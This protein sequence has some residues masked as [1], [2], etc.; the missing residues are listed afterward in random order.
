MAV[1]K[2][3][4][5]GGDLQIIDGK[6]TAQCEYC[7]CIQ[8]IASTSDEKKIALFNRANSLRMKNEF[9][10]A[11]AT[12]ENI[13][14]EYP[15]EVE[16]HWG[17]LLC[18]YGVEYVDDPR[19]KE[20]VPTCNRTQF[21]YIFDDEDYKFVINNCDVISKDLYVKEANKINKIQRGILEISQKEDPFDIF[22]CYKETEINSNQRTIDSVIAQDIY[23]ELTKKGY[24]V[25][26]SRVTLESKLGTMYEPYIFAA[27]NSSKVMLVIGSK[28]EHFNAVWVKN[29][30]SRYLE[31][32]NKDSKKYMIPCYKNMD[33]YDIPDEMLGFQSQD[34]NKIGFMQDLTRGI[35]KLIGRDLIRTKVES[36]ETVIHSDVNI[37]GLLTRAQMLIEDGDFKKADDVLERVLDNDPKN[38]DAYFY[39]L[40]VELQ[41]KN[42]KSL[43]KAD[44]DLPNYLNFTKAL[45]FADNEQK[46]NLEKIYQ[47]ILYNRELKQKEELYQEAC[48]HRKYKRFSAAINLFSKLIGYKDSNEQ[49]NATKKDEL[50][51][52]YLNGISSMRNNNFSQAIS[53]FEKNIDYKDSKELIE[54][55]RRNIEYNKKR[56]IYDDAK[57]HISNIGTLSVITELEK[58][59]DLLKKI[60]DFLDSNSL[61]KECENKIIEYKEEEKR[62]AEEEEKHRKKVK[63][64]AIRFTKIFAVVLTI[65]TAVLT[66]IFT[67]FIPL[68]KY[69]QGMD[70]LKKGEFDQA[71]NILYDLNGFLDS[72]K[73]L[74]IIEAKECFESGDY[75]TAIDHIYNIGGTVNVTYDTKG[76]NAEKTEEIIKKK[77]KYISNSCEKDGYT[78]YGWKLESYTMSNRNYTVD[79]KL[80]AS[81]E[82]IYYNINLNVDGGDLLGN[83]PTKYYI[84]DE[85]SIPNCEKTGYSFLGWTSYDIDTP[86]KDLV[87]RKGEQGNKNYTAVYAANTYTIYYD[88]GYDNIKREQ[89]VVYDSS[90]TTLSPQRNGY[91]FLGWKID[92]GSSYLDNG[93]FKNTKNINVK[94]QWKLKEYSISY[95]LNGGTNNLSNIKTFTI[96]D[97]VKIFEP[98]RL[99]YTFIGWQVNNSNDLTK[100]YTIPEGTYSNVSL[101]A[102]WEANE[103]QITFDSDGG[104][105]VDSVYVKYD[106]T[107]S[108]PLSEKTGYT[109]DGW[110]LENDEFT[111]NKWNLTKNIIL[112]AKWSANDNTA[113]VVNHNIEELNGEYTI[114]SSQKLSATSDSEVTPEVL[115][116]DGFTSPSTK[117]ITIN[118]DGSS[119]LDYYYTRNTY[120]LSY[121]SNGGN[122][123]RSR[124]LK[125]EEKIDDIIP[126]RENYTFGGWYTDVYLVNEFDN[127]MPSG[128]LTIYAYWNEE[129]KTSCFKFDENEDQIKI[130][131]SSNLP[132]NVVVPSYI[133]DDP[134]TIIGNEAFN[135][136]SNITSLYIPDNVT[137]M[138]AD[139]L[140]GCYSLN[141]LNL[142]FLGS[143][144]DDIGYN[145]SLGYLFGTNIDYCYK[146]TQILNSYTSG[147]VSK[148][149]WIPSQLEKITIRSGLIGKGTLSNV[150]SLKNINIMEDV[151]LI[152]DS[153][154]GGCYNLAELN[155]P[156]IGRQLNGVN[157]K[158]EGTL[159]Y[160][161][162]SISYTNSY[163]T[164]NPCVNSTYPT[165][166]YLPKSLI[167]VS[168]NDGV[169]N[170]YA[171]YNCGYLTDIVLNDKIISIGNHAFYSVTNLKNLIYSDEITEIEDYAFYGCTNLLLDNLPLNLSY[172]G[173]YAFSECG[174]LINISIFENILEIGEYVFSNCQNLE[175]LEIK[176]KPNL[177]GNSILYNSS[178]IKCI[179]VEDAHG[180]S[181]TTQYFKNSVPISLEKVCL[182]N[183]NNVPN[184]YFSNCENIKNIFINDSCE[185]IGEYAFSDCSSLLS[186]NIPSDVI[187]IGGGAFSGCSINKMTLPLKVKKIGDGAFSGA[188]IIDLYYKGNLNSWCDIE[189]TDDYSNPMKNSSYF[190]CYDDNENFYLP[191]NLVLNK[192][193]IGDYQ[194]YGGHQFES[195]ELKDVKHVGYGAFA[196][197]NSCT[198]IVLPDTIEYMGRGLFHGCSSLERITI[199]YLL[200]KFIEFFGNPTTDGLFLNKDYIPASL[201]SISILRGDISND[202]FY[203][204][205]NLTEIIL[206]DGVELIGSGAFSECLNLINVYFSSGL[207]K[208]EYGAFDRCSNLGNVYYNGTIEDWCNIDF[209]NEFSNPMKFAKNFYLYNSDNTYELIENI[210]MK[211]VSK[212]GAY[213][214]YGFEQLKSFEIDEVKEIGQYAFADCIKLVSLEIP[215]SV[216]K[217]NTGIFSGCVCLNYLKIPF[218]GSTLDSQYEFGDLFGQTYMEGLTAVK[219]RYTSTSYITYYLPNSLQKVEIASGVIKVGAFEN[220]EMI[221]EIVLGKN[222]SKIDEYAFSGCIN[223]NK[224]EL[225]CRN[226]TVC[227]KAF[228]N[229]NA[230]KT[231]YYHGNVMDWNT[232]DFAEIT[233]HPCKNGV[234]MYMLNENK[235]FY[236]VEDI[237][238][239][240][241]V[242]A[243]GEY[244]FVGFKNVKNVIISNSVNSIGFS[245][246]NGCSNLSSIKLPF[247]GTSINAKNYSVDTSFGRIFGTLSYVNSISARQS[248]SSD[249]YN[250]SIY[251]IPSTLI[252][253]EITN[254]IF[255][256]SFEFS[257][258]GTINIPNIQEIILGENIVSIPSYTFMGCKNM[259]KLSILGNVTSI[260]SAAFVACG[261]SDIELPSTL[262]TVGDSAFYNMPNLRNVYFKGTIDQ[263]QN[264]NF[265]SSNPIKNDVKLYILNDEEWEL[266]S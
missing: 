103:Y 116:L 96:E 7:G 174:S 60:P 214:F 256:Y 209:G 74:I 251:Q 265:S 85:I 153:A 218:L 163:E 17:V 183:C 123:I 94:A 223:I 245:S 97:S 156:F 65:V 28:Q 159:G 36:K 99:G 210:K 199:P 101:K 33:A 143:S 219:Q 207:T 90:F 130:I 31:L 222:I 46:V 230:L 68:S 79:V 51:Y 149:Y 212:I 157:G 67:F 178:S 61:I 233:G 53:I 42:I 23:D 124:K 187:E 10:K 11:M 158:L 62:K 141:S 109:F 19:T 55:C 242:T 194:F 20:K 73:Q 41:K 169:V 225:S 138:K 172:L 182:N 70:Y 25:F 134:V 50:E 181:F 128:N 126:E 216:E 150:I 250:Y 155:L 204:C 236:L 177:I 191:V 45:K 263:W 95:L 24:K 215:D 162:G 63:A 202:Y 81:Y 184:R 235:N 117:K 40:L 104:S 154:F 121:V 200:S 122:T 110:Y 71:Y 148:T 77:S 168:I 39:K 13:I 167:K 185:F 203:N 30:W 188:K 175:K 241:T 221:N 131:S 21:K 186:F 49:L 243:I 180:T 64:A 57:K 48:E 5:C 257:E 16:A 198:D 38:S 127:V 12:Y 72:D 146:V 211:K 92:G 170:D 259:S 144:R 197:C 69:Y 201:Y 108:L 80:V 119:V 4:M 195:I 164:K 213:Q 76:G 249:S 152:E 160:L 3:K 102:N 47:D 29:E 147:T 240:E 82:P 32:M 120:E 52:N 84:E 98:S 54:K 238:I 66:S 255:P 166:F 18:R 136:K 145:G 246:F 262:T 142:P 1:F 234:D 15:N 139:C 89:E 260:G 173:D 224:L 100:V 27:L 229:C 9:D 86:T 107:F 135:N 239:D 217:I 196:F 248:Y 176:G 226:L 59:I 254:K 190:Y 43:I 253:V 220:C 258:V 161:F 78:F 37:S 247:T 192:D 35:D 6:T 205:S 112:V 179:S 106:S 87:V 189:F 237:I 113:Y 91:E 56:K 137:E 151:T 14:M 44:V 261:F 227:N 125:Y 34:L 75:E 133:N 193:K 22:I 115:S 2:C 132:N 8:T 244:Q 105:K 140:S 111:I 83:C 93:V 266:V 206:G 58:A 231:I 232:I 26:F 118:P 228:Y 252:K 208:V 88:Y 165:K 114:Y 171:F 129:T 264:I